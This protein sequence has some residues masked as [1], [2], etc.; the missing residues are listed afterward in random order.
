M[1]QKLS[2]FMKQELNDDEYELFHELLE[3]FLKFGPDEV[4]SKVQFL[5]KT[6][7]EV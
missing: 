1:S 4:K 3:S 7:E 5:L 6:I 2:N